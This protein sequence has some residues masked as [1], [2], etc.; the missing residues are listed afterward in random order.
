VVNLMQSFADQSAIALENARLFS[1][2]ARKSHEPRC[3]GG[4]LRNSTQPPLIYSTQPGAAARS[5]QTKRR[6]L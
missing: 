6:M 5:S 4:L 3:G 1:E 2:I